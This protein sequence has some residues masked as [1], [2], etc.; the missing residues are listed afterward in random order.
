LSTYKTKLILTA[1]MFLIFACS[2]TGT[3]KN[4]R[5][6][7]VAVSVFPLYDFAT[8]V[9]GD[10]VAVRMLIPPGTGADDYELT[11][12]DIEAAVTADVFLF[13]SFEMEQWVYKIINAAAEKTNM[14]AVET[15]RGAFL[16]PASPPG[17]AQAD[18]AP[19]SPDKE[20]KEGIGYDPHIWLDFQNAQTM[21]ENIMTAFINKDP[22]NAK[23]YKRN[24]KICKLRLARLD[25]KYKTQLSVCATRAV[26]YA[27]D[28]PFA[29]QA[30]RYGLSYL[31]AYEI[32]T[33]E[34]P[35]AGE[36]L[37]LIS[38]IRKQKFRHIY[39]G[40]RT[41]PQIVESIAQETGAVLLKLS[42]GQNVRQEEIDGGITFVGL[43]EKNLEKLK[44]GMACP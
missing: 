39:Y 22:T 33:G 1:F 16:L 23:H 15:G 5:R 40:G 9:G 26:L 8:M 32:S 38:Q 42:D 28:W 37:N 24:A 11:K 29:Y 4:D 30:Q 20:Q 34:Q 44:T 41:V 36:M 12:R 2:N 19:A 27:G 35:A 31:P 10:K 14:L 18:F 7:Q 3:G 43:M 21:V 25:E 6:L 13:V 17:Q